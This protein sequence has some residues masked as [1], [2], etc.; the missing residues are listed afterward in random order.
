MNISKFLLLPRHANFN[1]KPLPKSSSVKISSLRAPTGS[2]KTQ[3]AIAL[4]FF[5]HL[6]PYPLPD[7]L[8]ENSPSYHTVSFN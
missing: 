6:S 5:T 1:T 3:T 8:S 7:C 4:P 2:G